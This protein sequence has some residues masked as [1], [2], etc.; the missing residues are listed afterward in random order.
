MSETQPTLTQW[1]TLY[2][3]C[4][5]FRK[6]ACWKWITEDHVFGIENPKTGEVGY[7][8]II[9]K[10]GQQLGI[11]IYAG[12]D[13]LESYKNLPDHAE[14]SEED[15]ILFLS[16]KCL[17]I[18]YDNK[19]GLSNEDIQVIEELGITLKGARQY[20]VIRNMTPGYMPW[21]ISGD[22]AEYL[23]I[24]IEQV[25]DV[26][27]R[28]KDNPDFIRTKRP[29]YLVR[30]NDTISGSQVWVDEWLLPEPIRQKTVAP[31]QL[32]EVGIMRIKLNAEKKK[33]TWE[34]TYS[35]ENM[36]VQEQG[37]RPFYPMMLLLVETQNGLILGSDTA[38]P[39]SYHQQF[40]DYLIQIMADTNSYPQEIMFESDEAATMLQPVLS[41]LDIKGIKV[42]RC[43]ESFKARNGLRQHLSNQH[44]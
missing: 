39:D 8:C 36:P 2:D 42:K 26:S 34:F 35:L 43:K 1:K 9:G 28:F 37:N 23:S 4:M 32:D 12:T 14:P 41:R 15:F 44:K 24:A 40:V 25:L 19:S 11:I 33:V 17:S 30:M 7:C 5:R 16:Q 10:L 31:A 13:G 18:I 29:K 20:P 27:K 3:A 21:F 22:E 6:A 38:S